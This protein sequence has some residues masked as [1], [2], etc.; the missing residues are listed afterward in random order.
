MPGA[1][2]QT[3]APHFMDL[4]E[5][6]VEVD[7]TIR[8]PGGPR[9]AA[10]LAL[11]MI[12]A[13]RRVTADAITAAL[14]DDGR[15][16][17]ISTLE[18]HLWRLRQVLEPHRPA[19]HR[20]S[21]LLTESG[22]Y[23]LVVTAD[24]VDS[25][26]FESLLEDASVLLRQRQPDRALQRCDQARAL[27]R[28]RP[29]DPVTDREWAAPA[30][31][32][33]QECR[34][35]L[36]ER[37]VDALL[38]V[39]E[40]ERALRELE[41]ALGDHPLR[42]HLWAQ[43]MLATYRTGRTDAALETFQKARRVFLDELGIEPGEQ[44]RSLHQR[45]LSKDPAL[46]E[47]EPARELPPGPD[48][49]GVVVHLP[50]RTTRLIGRADELARLTQLVRQHSLVTVTGS[51]GTGKTRLAAEAACDVVETFPDGI[52]FVDLTATEDTDQVADA[53]STAL[54]TPLPP[55]GSRDDA[56]RMFTR[57]RRML[58]LLDNCE[59]VLDEVATLTD[60]LRRTGPELS[61]LATSREPLDTD[62]E[63]VFALGPLALPG[64]EQAGR[65][66]A[67]VEL[68]LERLHGRADAL[69]V[70]TVDPSTAARICRAVDG[71]PLAI[72]LAAARART[73]SL[74]DVAEQVEAD[75]AALSQVGRARRGHRA[76]VHAAVEW[77][78][79]LLTPG[80]QALHRTVSLLPGPFTLA[81]ASAAAGR[82]PTDA[83]DLL[84]DL[85][86]RSLLAPLGPREP[87]RPSRFAQ[88]AT[89][90]GHGTRAL[91]EAGEA[92]AHR[93]LRNEWVR[94]LAT[95]ARPRL[96]TPQER[97]WFDQLDD[98]YATLRGVLQHTL[99]DEP[100]PTGA[101]IIARTGM[102]WYS[103]GALL[104]GRRWTE[105]AG[106][107][108]AGVTP[109]AS[110]MVDLSLS[111]IWGFTGRGDL[112]GSL[113]DRGLGQ[114]PT[115]L[116]PDDEL[117]LGDHLTTVAGC[118]W[119]AGER[120]RALEVLDRVEQILRRTG[121]PTLALLHRIRVAATEIGHRRCADIVADMAAAHETAGEADN[122]FASWFSATVAGLAALACRDGSTALH[123][124]SISIAELDGAGQYQ[125]PLQ[126]ELR[127][128]ALTL[129]GRFDEALRCYSAARTQN[130]RAGVP[131]PGVS[132]TAALLAQARAGT[133]TSAGQRAWED[134]ALLSLHDLAPV[135]PPRDSRV[136]ISGW[137]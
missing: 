74:R 18:S 5:I 26:R 70:D 16:R 61:V 37:H 2:I 92:E 48:S 34:A 106:R 46:T 40:P 56:I 99:V 127:G 80:E 24:Q 101:E 112:A 54:G 49:G 31:A 107:A 136:S 66:A 88:L 38:G 9:P 3:S 51:A 133:S 94:A 125:V 36:D 32:R 10:A 108:T 44:L 73:F 135:Q 117:L 17:S 19:G 116:A 79:R 6:L 95:T 93:C 21:V 114:V 111:A 91:V 64:S 39:G 81:A 89:V 76:T 75:P 129:L 42:E 96:G 77:S 121:D 123:W 50:P 35:Q 132:G 12:N 52:W 87:G 103:R 30:V 62:H 98:D 63:H 122:Q 4:G 113:C 41:T 1:N 14:W 84:A 15:P 131:W 22:G 78:Y 67:A 23:R 27:W 85:A 69:S 45:I 115:A 8:T 110:A 86:H 7:Q 134:G 55:T 68:F 104:E 102:Y 58:L 109:F 90:R 72:E 97:S 59:H 100:S 124:S 83:A 82:D 13:N 71:V 130:I 57:D 29:F 65:V 60:A 137:H 20:S 28:G 53:I 33:L 25:L 119:T 118:L 47:Q 43:R 105:L 120:Q 126:L 11:L 128:N